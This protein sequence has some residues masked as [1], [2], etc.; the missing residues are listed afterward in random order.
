MNSEIIG[1]PSSLPWSM[2]F[3]QPFENA[4]REL[5][6]L[7]AES[8]YIEKTSISGSETNLIPLNLQVVFSPNQTDEKTVR[9]FAEQ[10]IPGLI[11][12]SN[13]DEELLKVPDVSEISVRKEASGAVFLSMRLLGIAR[14]P[15]M[16]Y[17]AISTL[18]LFFILFSI[19]YKNPGMPEGRLFGLFVAL[20]FSLRFAYEFLKENQ[21]AFEDNLA[22]NMGQVLSIPLFFAGIFILI[23][24]FRQKE[25]KK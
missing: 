2:V 25:I 11:A 7:P 9:M 1:K 12:R 8:F 4:L 23:R 6:D 3:I 18:L 24:S 13:A 16:V 5:S 14:H 20:L 10:I 22:L 17:E 15:A 21:V 19:W